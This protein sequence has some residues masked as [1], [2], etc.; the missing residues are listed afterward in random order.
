VH[1]PSKMDPWE[2]E[3]PEDLNYTI[4]PVNGVFHVYESQEKAEK[5]ECI[6]YPY[7]DLA[8]FVGDM[9]LL[10]AMIADGPLYAKSDERK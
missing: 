3:Y 8:N 7:Y 9:N 10:C 2:I 5:E 4:K 1:A 6:N